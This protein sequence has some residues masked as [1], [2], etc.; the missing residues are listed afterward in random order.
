MQKFFENCKIHLKIKFL[1]F[2]KLIIKNSKY[3]ITMWP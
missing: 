3:K 1:A 2:I